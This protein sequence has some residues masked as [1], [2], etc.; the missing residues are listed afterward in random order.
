[1]IEIENAKKE[2]KK[3][4]HELEIDSPKVQAKLEHIFRVSE[5]S[6]KIATE[7]KL[8]EEQIRLAELIGILHDIGRFEQYRRFDK[9]TS[10]KTEDNSKMFNHGEAGV[11]ILKNN[12]YIRKYIQESKYDTIIYTAVYEHNRYEISE[13]LTAEEELF[14]KIIRD[15]DKI[16]LIYEAIGVYWQKPEKIEKIEMGTLS[17][18]ML[19]NFYEHKLADKRNKIEET[20]EILRFASFV[21]DINFSYSFKVFKENNNITKMIDRFNYKVPETKKEMMKIKKIANEYVEEN[22]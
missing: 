12:N 13:K 18:K 17:R 4:V 7:L 21:F 3:H 19:G 11:K 14:C 15:A 20:D 6:K 16:D 10:S 1:M 5:I 9:N 2:L 22:M 8:T